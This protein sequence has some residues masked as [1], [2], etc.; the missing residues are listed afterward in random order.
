ML[1]TCTLFPQ[2]LTQ[3]WTK[4]Y[5]LIPHFVKS[6]ARKGVFPCGYFHYRLSR[7]STVYLENKE[8]FFYGVLTLAY[9]IRIQRYFWSFQSNVLKNNFSGRGS[10]PAFWR[11]KTGTEPA[12]ETLCITG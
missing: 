5:R 7:E 12:C 1:S 6:V 11:L 2:H 4:I 3:M 9:D 8:R 10:V